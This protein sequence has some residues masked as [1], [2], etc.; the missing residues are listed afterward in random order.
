[1]AREILELLATPYRAVAA[2][3]IVRSEHDR[4]VPPA[5]KRAEAEQRRRGAGDRL[6]EPLTL[7][8]HA[9]VPPRANGRLG[10]VSS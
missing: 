1:M 3:A 4:G 7:G 5:L 6:V 8:L 9:E 2:F 10:P